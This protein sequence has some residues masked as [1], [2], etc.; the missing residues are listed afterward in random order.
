MDSPFV[1]FDL[2]DDPKYPS[3]VL[4][5]RRII[6]LDVGDIMISRHDDTF[7]NFDPYNGLAVVIQRILHIQGIE[8]DVIDQVF[9]VGDLDGFAFH[10]ALW[11]M[12]KE[13]QSEASLHDLLTPVITKALETKSFILAWDFNPTLT[14]ISY[15]IPHSISYLIR[16]A[17]YLEV[18]DEL[19]DEEYLST[20]LAMNDLLGALLFDS[21]RLM[22][23]LTSPQLNKGSL[24]YSKL[25]ASLLGLP[26]KV[27]DRTL[28]ILED[29]MNNCIPTVFETEA[30]N[31]VKAIEE[32]FV[33]DQKIN[34][35]QADDNIDPPRTLTDMNRYE[36]NYSQ[37]L[38]RRIRSSTFFRT[39]H[40]IPGLH[41][42]GGNQI[43][44]GDRV[45]LFRNMPAPILIRPCEEPD[46]YTFV[47]I[48]I[49]R[50]VM[51]GELH[52]LLKEE[53][54]QPKVFK[55]R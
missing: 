40:G 23:E 41:P 14:M 8:L 36:A 10:H 53:V 50:G 47:G 7:A 48:A 29:I 49:V 17:E 44:K 37:S 16:I 52:D 24:R 6:P 1:R 54:V 9:N 22:E 3:W 11:H 43:R 45:V 5:F 51:D 4:D 31:I 30:S 12:E 13:F 18:I 39:K 32:R 42:I 21:A 27:K 15:I 25:K 46:V 26:G 38:V 34:Q 55:I 28:A 35:Q 20:S 2:L 19:N 33:V